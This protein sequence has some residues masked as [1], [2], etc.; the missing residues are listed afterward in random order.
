M[1]ALSTL[2][3]P[4]KKPA[5]ICVDDERT[6]LSSLKTQLQHNLGNDYQI[7]I[8]E[9][10]EECLEL[11][12]EFRAAHIE[13]PIIITDQ[14]MPTLNGDELMV[15]VKKRL[16][17]TLTIML[18]GQAT[19]AAVGAALNHA[20]LYRFIAKPWHEE[21]LILTIRTGIQ[22]YFQSQTLKQKERYQRILQQILQLV[23]NKSELKHRINATLSLLLQEE[24]FH[25][26]N[27]G[28]IFIRNEQGEMEPLAQQGC[29]K[30]LAFLT[31]QLTQPQHQTFTETSGNPCY[32]IDITNNQQL[33]GMIFLFAE[34]EQTE[35]EHTV[36]FLNSVADT[37]AGM[38]ELEYYHRTIVRQN[39]E[40]EQKIV[41]R[42]KELEEA[43]HKQAQ[44]NATFIDANKKL[45]YYATT[46][47][48]TNLANRRHFIKCAEQLI[49][50]CNEAHTPI[51]L[52]MID[53]D[54]FKDI[55]DTY[56]H[57]TGDEVLRCFADLLMK[58]VRKDDLIGRLGGEEF[59]IVAPMLN[60]EQCFYLAD[61]I[62]LKSAEQPIQ[63]CNHS[64]F[65]TCSIGIA[66]LEPDSENI[67]DAL[68]RADSA[69]YRAKDNGRNQV[70]HHQ[71]S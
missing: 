44:L 48:L 28:A 34:A 64:L 38:I 24:T 35:N 21:D 69:L 71:L 32:Q 47:S 1:V 16:P 2:T 19:A 27:Q 66:E 10:G 15:E 60:Q 12:D 55:N 8:A 13:I 41:L 42:T 59:A 14:L 7:E 63:A 20:D 9:S 54:L 57:Q 17:D 26:V 58:T 56:G 4:K 40:L 49:M 67:F 61:R 46:D 70:T 62:R 33:M 52:M 31:A 22:S 53:L 5:I 3:K 36:A 65:I 29:E 45:E 39:E 43:L 68:A 37:L 11:V 50:Q 6:V 51:S 30:T 23:L 18:T 25:Q